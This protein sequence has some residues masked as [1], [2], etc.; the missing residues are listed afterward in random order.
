MHEPN[1]PRVIYETVLSD[2]AITDAIVHCWNNVV[3]EATLHPVYAE[4]LLIYW[5]LIWEIKHA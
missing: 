3:S 2:E 5:L 1:V 4:Q